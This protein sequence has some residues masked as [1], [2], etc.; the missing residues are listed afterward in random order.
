V[1]FTATAWGQPAPTQYSLPPDLLQK[2]KALY[3][4]GIV[5][6]VGGTVWGLVVLTGIVLLRIG[7]K[8][9]DVAVRVSRFRFVQALVFVPLVFGTLSLCS[10]PLEAYGHHLGLEY[11]LSVQPWAPWFLDWLKAFALDVSVA[12][13]LVWIFYAVIRR[14]PRRWWLYVWLIT[15]PVI[16]LLVFV[17][18]VVLDPIFNKFEPLATTRPDLV[19]QIDKVAERGG[20][21]I[22]P[23][24]MYEMKASEKVTTYNA[25]VTGFGAT[26]RVVVWDNTA[27]E[28]PTP[29]VLFIFGHEMG[30]YV[31]NHIWKGMAFAAGIGFI[32]LLLTAS[33]G[34]RIIELRGQ[35]WGIPGIS[36]LSSLPVLLLLLNLLLLCA[37]PA[38]SGFSRQ[39]EHDA[40]IYGLEVIHGLV[41]ESSN[42]AAWTF[43]HLGEKSLDYPHPNRLLVFWT[44]D[45]PTIADRL[46]FA[47][48]YRP[49]D[50]G[51]EP[52]YVW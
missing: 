47:L 31:L 35:D 25:Y 8:Y 23:N 29:E 17:A 42:I 37:S 20:L 10:L 38:M 32:L 40:D 49:W 22:P 16:L 21:Q 44:Y 36:D 15:L 18:P 48:Q 45:H 41:P 52:R 14:S 33:F 13:V 5:L 12:A 11:G 34:G 43:Q 4:S 50:Y 28:L 26:K 2:S 24:R 39:L 27:R 19:K 30:H 9:R 1:L 51:T 3:E 7:K 46:V 6:T